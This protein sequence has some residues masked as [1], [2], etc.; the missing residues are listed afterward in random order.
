MFFA[1]IHSYTHIFYTLASDF[2]EKGTTMEHILNVLSHH[3]ERIA[4]TPIN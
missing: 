3:G 4:Q 1:L 2:N